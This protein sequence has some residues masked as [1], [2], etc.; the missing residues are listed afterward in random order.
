MKIPE[1]IVSNPNVSEKAVIAA[2]SSQLPSRKYYYSLT[3][4]SKILLYTEL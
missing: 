3:V 4:K 2:L 1:E